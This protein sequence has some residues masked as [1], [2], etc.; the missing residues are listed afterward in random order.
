MVNNNF[1]QNWGQTNYGGYSSQPRYGSTPMNSNII[2]VISLEDAIMRTNTRGSDMLYVDQDKDRFYRV[3]VDY[4]GN[5]TWGEFTFSSSQNN[6]F[7]TASRADVEALEKRLE[8]LEKLI[9][10]KQTTNN[11]TLTEAV[12]NG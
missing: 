11:P 9:T 12:Q 5:K 10:A 8:S 1:D 4:E 2:R 3:R 7:A 6:Q